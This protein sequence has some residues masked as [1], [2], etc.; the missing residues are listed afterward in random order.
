MREFRGSLR[1]NTPGCPAFDL[2]S[3]SGDQEVAESG[4][5]AGGSFFAIFFSARTLAALHVNTSVRHLVLDVTASAARADADL[6][7]MLASN[8]G[9]E[10]VSVRQR[11]RRWTLSRAALLGESP[12]TTPQR[13]SG[14]RH[15]LSRSSSCIPRVHVVLIKSKAGRADEAATHTR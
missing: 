14:S 2:A 11:G 9:I 5:G 15:G 3:A 6:L 1:W 4:A 8:V 10:S 7:A 13:S 12:P